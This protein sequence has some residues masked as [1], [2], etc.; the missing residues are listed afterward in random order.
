MV[1]VYVPAMLTTALCVVAG[2]NPA[3]PDH[4]YENPL[5]PCVTVNVVFVPSQIAFVPV[6]TQFGLAFTVNLTSAEV[7]A[8]QLP[9]GVTITR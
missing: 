2:V 5:P 4:E 3:G 1:T 7:A 6:I 9:V 8:A